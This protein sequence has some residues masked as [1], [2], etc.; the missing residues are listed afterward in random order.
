MASRRGSKPFVPRRIRNEDERSSFSSDYIQ[1]AEG[2]K[3]YGYALF[4]GD[5]KQDEPGYYEYQEHYDP[6]L[7]KRGSSV[8]CNTNDCVYCEAG[9]R[10][11]TRAKTLWLITQIGDKKLKTPELRIWNANF[12]VINTLTTMRNEGDPIMGRLF[13]VVRADD[14]GTYVFDRR[15]VKPLTKSEIKTTL[16]KAPDFEAMLTAQGKRVYD[17]L[18]AEQL[19]AEDDEDE[20]EETPAPRSSRSQAPAGRRS[21]KGA[22]AE[23]EQAEEEEE[24][25]QP[26]E[27]SEPEEMPEEAEDELVVVRRVYTRGAQK[28]MMSVSHEAYGD[29]DVWGTSEINITQLEAGDEL[30]IS[31]YTDEEGDVVLLDDPKDAGEVADGGEASELPHEIE[32]EVFVVTAVNEDEESL[33]VENDELGLSFPLYFMQGLQIEWGDYEP[34]TKIKVTAE[35]DSY[36]TMVATDV[37]EKVKA[38]ARRRTAARR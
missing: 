27:E 10:P 29:F 28:N 12:F 5:P 37:P 18:A 35:Q 36:G 23:P 17:K 7:G 26:E 2:E 15:E 24:T 3:F 4:N 31:W 33:D 21:A 6:G 8:P 38:P 9:D 19:Y 16:E 34:G 13:R 25:E 32:N 30:L 22:V 11:K 14:R 1:L 20:Q